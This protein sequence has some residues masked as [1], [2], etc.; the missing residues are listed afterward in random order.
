M[1]IMNAVLAIALGLTPA[2]PGK[3][4]Q[5]F[6]YDDRVY[7]AI[8]GSFRQVVDRR[9]TRHLRGFHRM[10][11]QSFDLAVRPDG[12]VEGTVGYTYMTFTVRDDT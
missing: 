6:S 9:G 7:S 2:Q 4:V 3:A 12:N 10:T 1:M 5:K 11:N 8:V